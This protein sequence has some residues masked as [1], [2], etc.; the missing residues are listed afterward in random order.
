[1]ANLADNFVF[2]KIKSSSSG[3]YQQY[4]TDLQSYAK[5]II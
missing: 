1:M 5:G 4:L 3:L 2:E